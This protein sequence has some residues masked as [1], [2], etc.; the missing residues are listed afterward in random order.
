MVEQEE[1]Q[2]AASLA[3]AFGARL[4]LRH[5]A[6]RATILTFGGYGAGQA[7]RF[8]SNLI[9]T[10]LLFPEAFGLMVLVNLV[11]QGL[12]M[13]SDIGLGPSV[14]QN[15]RGE[16]PVFL[17]TAW[18]VNILKNSG[19][20]VVACLLSWP[21]AMLYREP[22]LAA[23]LPVVAV[24]LILMAA[25]SAQT[26]VLRRRLELGKLILL[27]LSTYTLSVI[28]MI[29]VAWV[30]PSVW[31]LAIGTLAGGAALTALS[32]VAL[33]GPGMRFALDREVIRQLFR[34]GRWLFISS[35]LT[36]FC[37]QLDRIVL[38]GFMSM[39]ELGVYSIAF[40]LAQTL[41]A[42]IET[43]AQRVLFPL[44]SRAAELGTAHLRRQAF[45]FRVA[46]LLASLPP[47]WALTVFGP[48]IVAFL[49]PVAYHGA[50]QML[51]V[52]SVGA[53]F[54]LVLVPIE[55]VLLGSGDSF[56]HLV[57]QAIKSAC[58]IGAM[59]VGGGLYGAWGV[60]FSFAASRVVYYPA[61][62]LLIRRYGVW[63]PAL[64]FAAFG[65]SAGII[66]LGFWIKA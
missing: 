32:H 2:Q 42:V 3:Q 43:V 60:I 49:Y 10:R 36:F 34:F 44:Y 30:Y 46:L 39:T 14:V 56:R 19:L 27:E 41:V 62:A 8:A 40:M 38:G 22:E 59:C 64:D 18:T 13:F 17:R 7:L 6:V 37:G 9:L 63:M 50:G 55:N 54:A 28:V 23:L 4:S 25:V 35:I 16:E 5:P 51:Q 66:L 48:E 21:L 26:G 58:M 33:G 11:I 45:R 15:P 57:L 12:Q 52:L 53:I 29:G 47:M 24:N 61:Q 20:W 1:Q 31:A 65:V